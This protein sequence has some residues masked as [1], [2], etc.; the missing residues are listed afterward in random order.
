MYIREDTGM[1]E[2][3]TIQTEGDRMFASFEWTGAWRYGESGQLRLM[4]NPL[5]VLRHLPAD[6]FRIYF[7]YYGPA[8]NPDAKPKV[9]ADSTF[10][11]EP[12]L[13]DPNQYSFR[14]FNYPDRYIRHRDFHLYT[15]PI[16][17]YPDH[18]YATFRMS[19]PLYQPRY[20]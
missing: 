18:Q 1:G 6:N 10:I 5:I 14:S 12:G 13:V 3:T 11:L 20:C 7:N 4:I 15:E 19:P 16:N 2:L 9:L 17:H 8:L